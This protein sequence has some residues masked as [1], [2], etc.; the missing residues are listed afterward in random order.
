MWPKKLI[1]IAARESLDDKRYQG[2]SG[3]PRYIARLWQWLPSSFESFDADTWPTFDGQVMAVIRSTG[4]AGEIRVTFEAE[5]C[6]KAQ[7][8]LI[9][10]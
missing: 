6:E 1:Q 5:G 7:I 8:T 10:K 9:S 3:W 4:E 2:D